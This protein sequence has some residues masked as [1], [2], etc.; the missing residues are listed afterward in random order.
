M[1]RVW[2]ARTSIV[3]A[4]DTSQRL[5]SSLKLEQPLWELKMP[6]KSATLL[7]FHFVMSP[8]LA[9]RAENRSPGSGGRVAPAS[10]DGPSSFVTCGA[11]PIA[12]SLSLHH[13]LAAALSSSVELKQ[14]GASVQDTAHAVHADR[15]CAQHITSERPLRGKRERARSARLPRPLVIRARKQPAR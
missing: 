1:E 7:T 14:F 11:L 4:P 2:P 3:V 9:A 15:S 10:H 8:Y 12:A 6:L 13:A 5:M